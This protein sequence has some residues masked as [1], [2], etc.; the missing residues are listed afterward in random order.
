MLR[1]LFTF[2][3]VIVRP[4]LNYEYYPISISDRNNVKA[5]ANKNNKKNRQT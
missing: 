4:F 2:Y 1:K 5:I 3:V